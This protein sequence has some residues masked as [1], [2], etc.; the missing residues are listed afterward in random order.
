[1]GQPDLW[2]WMGMGEGTGCNPCLGAPTAPRSR[3]HHG[4]R[5]IPQPCSEEARI[6]ESTNALTVI[7]VSLRVQTEVYYSKRCGGW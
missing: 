3:Q 4:P 7:L 6:Q 1:M 5:L 2:E